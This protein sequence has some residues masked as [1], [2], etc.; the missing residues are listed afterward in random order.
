MNKTLD[1]SVHLYLCCIVK[2]K[3]DDISRKISKVMKEIGQL[4]R[5]EP[6]YKS[7]RTSEENEKQRKDFCT[8]SSIK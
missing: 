4:Q 5:A 7:I 3:F 1:V 6:G 2:Q 8:Y